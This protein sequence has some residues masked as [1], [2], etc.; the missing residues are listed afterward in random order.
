MTCSKSA[1]AFRRYATIPSWYLRH[2]GPD[3]PTRNTCL[4][5]RPSEHTATRIKYMHLYLSQLPLVS[6]LKR[7]E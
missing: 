4:E 2:R 6:L 5:R 1:R 3:V 7:H